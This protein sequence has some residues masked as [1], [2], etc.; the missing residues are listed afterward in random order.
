MEQIPAPCQCSQVERHIPHKD[1]IGG[2]NPLAGTGLR[3]EK[4]EDAGSNP[5]TA[6]RLAMPCSLKVE[7]HKEGKKARVRIPSRLFHRNVYLSG[8]EVFP[9]L[10]F[11][12]TAGRMPLEH[13]M[14]VR[15][16]QGQLNETWRLCRRGLV[17][18]R[19]ES[20]ASLKLPRCR[21][22]QHDK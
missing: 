9:L 16:H 17:S 21:Q 18:Y 6:M 15:I 2:S 19:S 5:V 3:S 13:L 4:V 8:L 11:R 7:H 14:M 22:R 20:R 1:A 12:S 10:P